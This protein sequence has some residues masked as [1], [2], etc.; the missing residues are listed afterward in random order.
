MQP[1]TLT[2]Q[3]LFPFP[4][5]NH[6]FIW[7]A[8]YSQQAGWERYEILTSHEENCI[9]TYVH[10]KI[11]KGEWKPMEE[12]SPLSDTHSLRLTALFPS[13]VWLHPL[14]LSEEA[15]GPQDS[16]GAGDLACALTFSSCSSSLSKSLTT[17]LALPRFGLFLPFPVSRPFSSFLLSLIFTFTDFARVG[18][19]EITVRV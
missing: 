12:L 17:G 10:E 3:C 15:C 6:Y 11:G 16:L 14:R 2:S 5:S 13:S 9:C 19:K 18:T 8:I 4:P 1:K 7:S